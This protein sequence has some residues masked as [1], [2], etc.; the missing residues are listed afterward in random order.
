[1][2]YKLAT[3]PITN[4]FVNTK[5]P[6]ISKNSFFEWTERDID[7]FVGE[8]FN[9]FS[10]TTTTTTTTTATTAT[11]TTIT[12]DTN[13]N[14][15]N[16][17]WIGIYVYS[18]HVLRG[19][20][21][22]MLWDGQHRMVMCNLILISLRDLFNNPD[23]THQI[24]NLLMINGTPKLECLISNENDAL[25]NILLQ[26]KYYI[27]EFYSQDEHQNQFICTACHSTIGRNDTKK[28]L[29]ICQK[30]KNMQHLIDFDDSSKI[31]KAFY[32]CKKI[33]RKFFEN[34]E[35]SNIN[36]SNFFKFFTSIIFDRYRI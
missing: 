24:N 11:T 29:L 15:S 4:F 14:N 20:T 2:T 13:D 28:H 10:T 16:K 21:F 30:I 7:L 36:A 17:Y 5:I 19:E 8:I 27:L 18:K 23:L 35:F 6:Y 33:L 31:Y 22:Y 12:T 3:L 9:R 25:K 32:Y 1:M 34:D 26:K